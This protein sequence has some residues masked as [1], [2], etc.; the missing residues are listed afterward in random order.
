M[1]EELS[2]RVGERGRVVTQARFGD[3]LAD[4]RALKMQS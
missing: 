3:D 4:S 1:E 2:A